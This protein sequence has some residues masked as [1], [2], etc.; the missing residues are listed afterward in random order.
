MYHTIEKEKH[1]KF[2]Q[3]MIR[4]YYNYATNYSL[5]ILGTSKLAKAILTVSNTHRN[6]HFSAK[7]VGRLEIINLFQINF[8]K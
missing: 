5:Y 6:K 8:R 2:Q 1:V 7:N 3:H 4:K